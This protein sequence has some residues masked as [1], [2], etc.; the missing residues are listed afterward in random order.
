MPAFIIVIWVA[1]TGGSAYIV[2][3]KGWLRSGEFTS[4]TACVEAADN[5]KVTKFKCVKVQK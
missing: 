3:E 1:T 2:Y 4:E 5:Q